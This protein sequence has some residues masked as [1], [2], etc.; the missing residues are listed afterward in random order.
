MSPINKNYKISQVCPRVG[1]GTGYASAQPNKKESRLTLSPIQTNR[2][3]RITRRDQ[4]LKNQS[5]KPDSMHE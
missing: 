2:Q 4:H 3:L 1:L 5:I